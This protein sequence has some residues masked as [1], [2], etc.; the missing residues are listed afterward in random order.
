MAGRTDQAAGDASRS[1]SPL[2]L[3]LGRDAGAVEGIAQML[4][5]GGVRVATADDPHGVQGT[6]RGELPLVALVE[7]GL[8][9]EYPDV[10]ELPRRRGGATILWHGAEPD[11]VV[12]TPIRRAIL[13]EV[14][15][16]LERTRLLALVR[17][18]AARTVQAGHVDGAP[19]AELR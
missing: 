11:D 1:P 10:L 3:V 12:V 9:T 14:Q 7:R 15:L 19:S 8:A 16:P 18:V 13:A 17:H 4:L 5:A 6:M 2:V